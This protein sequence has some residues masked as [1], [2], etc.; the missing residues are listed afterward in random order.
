MNWNELEARVLYTEDVLLDVKMRVKELTG[1]TILPHLPPRDVECTVVYQDPKKLN[2]APVT[3][4]CTYTN[5]GFKIKEGDQEVVANPY[6]CWR[7][8]GSGCADDPYQDIIIGWLAACNGA[9]NRGGF[10]VSCDREEWL[11]KGRE[12]WGKFRALTPPRAVG[13]GVS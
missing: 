9:N 1:R 11:T 10:R 5:G 6:P 13:I 3:Y 4:K 2:A 12:E 7:D 8:L